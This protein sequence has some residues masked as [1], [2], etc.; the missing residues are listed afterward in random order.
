MIKSR[1]TRF[2]VCT[3]AMAIIALQSWSSAADL[4]GDSERSA[5]L[6][7]LERT[8]QKAGASSAE[9]AVFEGWVKG[10]SREELSGYAEYLDRNPS[11]FVRLLRRE[12][13][14]EQMPGPP[15]IFPASAPAVACDALQQAVIA[16]TKIDSTSFEA[17]DGSC[18]ITAIVTHHPGDNHIKVFIALPS[19]R[20]NGRFMGTGG[21]GYAGGSPSSLDAP[22][23]KG[24]AVG[25]TDTGNPEGTAKFAIDSNGKPAWQR[26]R[27][28][29]YLGIHDMTVVGKA[30]TKAF[31]GKAPRYSYFLGGSTGGRQA[32]TE[33]QRY[34][35]DY[36]GILALSPAIARDRYV[37]AQ[38]WP[39]VVMLDAND[40]LSLEKREAATAAAVKAC[41]GADGVVDGVIDDPMR[42]KYDPVALV[43]TKIGN[44]TFTETDARVIREIWQGAKAHDGSFLWWGPTPGTELTNLANT[45][46]TPLAGKPCE[47]G[48]DWFRYFLVLDPKWD[49]KTLTRGEFELLFLQSI[50]EYASIYGGDDPNLVGFRDRGGK[51]LIVHGLADEFVPPQKTIDYY[52]A[53]QQRMDGSY[54]TASFIRLFLVPGADHD[55]ATPVPTPSFGAAFDALIQW[56][57][58]GHAPEQLLAELDGSDGKPVRTRPL[59]PYPRVARYKGSGSPNVAANFISTLPAR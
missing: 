5:A 3:V 15:A 46:G 25:A 44:T 28:N 27:D 45:E 31:Y 18:R 24:Y 22:A 8:L 55:Y 26:M 36:D 53:V 29:A 51:L 35:Q 9:L 4:P 41:D 57:E 50:Q 20:W 14:E 10:T 56:V 43:G 37:P 59:F 13:K 38:L 54:D 23:R 47:E 2:A 52:S 16:D 33:A 7:K 11:N 40:F 32:L 30:L 12:V 1:P 17:S 21:G 58:N 19:K 42:C 6:A 48:L 49:W 39:Q 34:P